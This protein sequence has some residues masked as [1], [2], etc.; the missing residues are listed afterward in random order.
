MVKLI[1]RNSSTHLHTHTHTCTQIHTGCPRATAPSTCIYFKLRASAQSTS[2]MLQHKTY[3]RSAITA[4]RPHGVR[5]SLLHPPPASS[6]F[7]PSFPFH[8]PPA[9]HPPPPSTPPPSSNSV[10]AVSLQRLQ[11]HL[12]SQPPSSAFIRVVIHS[13]RALLSRSLW[14]TCSRTRRSAASRLQTPELCTSPSSP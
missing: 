8:P 12:L 6:S 7:S 2:N 5:I 14:H 10:P 1:P 9:A 11:P 3:H 4:S 13:R